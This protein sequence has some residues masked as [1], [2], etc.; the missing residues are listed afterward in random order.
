MACAFI[1]GL[2]APSF[3]PQHSI[4]ADCGWNIKTVISFLLWSF[5]YPGSSQSQGCS[6]ATTPHRYQS[7]V[8]HTH[9]TLYGFWASLAVYTDNLTSKTALRHIKLSV[10][11]IYK[12]VYYDEILNGIISWQNSRHWHQ[13]SSTRTHLDSCDTLA[14]C[15]SM[16]VLFTNSGLFANGLLEPW[17]TQFFTLRQ[18]LCLW[19]TGRGLRTSPNGRVSLWILGSNSVWGSEWKCSELKP[20]TVKGGVCRSGD[21]IRWF[22][23][24]PF[25]TRDHLVWLPRWLSCRP[26]LLK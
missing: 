2:R 21:L 18:T 24:P 15:E 5:I 6:A 22:V 12:V 10:H 25:R 19:N 1:Y 3:F 17:Q 26:W 4:F 14:A 23:S 11:M 8:F 9:Y 7:S 16:W 20:L 13:N